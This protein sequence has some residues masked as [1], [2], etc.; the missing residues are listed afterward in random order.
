MPLTLS[1]AALAADPWLTF[2]G[3]QGPGKGKHVVL[4]AGDEEYRSE[5]SMPMFG[6]LLA[7]KHGFTCTV[8]FSINPK[9]GEIDPNEQTNIPGMEALDSADFVILA[10]RFRELPDKDMKH[11]VDY[12]EAGKP[13]LGLRTATHAFAYNRDKSSPYAKW[14][15][16]SKE[17][18]GGFGKQIFG[19]T[20]VNHHGDHGSQS[21]HA[22]AEEINRSHPLLRGVSDV[23]GPTDVYAVDPL[24][25]DAK[26]LMRGQVL[27]G[28]TPESEAVKGP[29][30]DP[31]MPVIW[32]RD[33]TTPEG[34][35]QCVIC[36]TMGAAVD[37]VHPGL[38]RFVVNATYWGANIK[39]PETLD[40][41]PVG[42]Y[43]PSP[44]GNDKFTKGVKP[45]DLPKK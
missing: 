30:N 43:N 4:I 9:T 8:L 3:K 18:P 20:W 44:F 13:I 11:F 33:R 32:L 12:I 45:A 36:T 34:K 31:M 14:S 1:T 40:A 21:T 2:E 35:N 42:P 29:K 17:W 7:E 27:S 15:F 5:E 23:W 37:F 28:M 22:I 39:I 38:R 26:V 10:T 24:P 16:D 25:A 41:N 19:E 6:K